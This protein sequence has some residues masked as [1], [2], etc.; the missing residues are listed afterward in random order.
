MPCVLDAL[1]IG[2]RDVH[3]EGGGGVGVSA[4]GEV[5]VPNDLLGARRGHSG[6]SLAE[7]IRALTCDDN[8]NDFIEGG[9]QRDAK[10][11][12]VGQT[13]RYGFRDLIDQL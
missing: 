11:D 2:D 12:A 1:S 8:V 7:L 10:T 3:L 13:P 5:G 9:L 6:T 4:K